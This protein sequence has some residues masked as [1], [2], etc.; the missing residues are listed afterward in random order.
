MGSRAAHEMMNQ[1]FRAGGAAGLPGPRSERFLPNG[2]AAAC[3]LRR[4]HLAPK[5]QRWN[6]A[7]TA[8]RIHRPHAT[9]APR[10][11]IPVMAYANK[12]QR[13]LNG[14]LGSPMRRGRIDALHPARLAVERCLPPA[15]NALLCAGEPISLPIRDGEA[16][17]MRTE[18]PAAQGSP[19]RSETSS[20]YRQMKP[21]NCGPTP[22]RGTSCGRRRSPGTTA[23][24]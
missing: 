3:A 10:H 14:S 19:S 15:A 2:G 16:Y 11:G 21:G 4:P 9:V 13:R 18:T 6:C 7:S 12:R 5:G 20:D 8:W 23:S 1:R 22:L 17:H 24:G